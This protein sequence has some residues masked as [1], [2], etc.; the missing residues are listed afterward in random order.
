MLGAGARD[1]LD[2]PGLT[3][4]LQMLALVAF[5][6]ALDG[7]EQIGP[8]R[9]RA[10][11]AAPQPAGDGVHQE[12]R[13]RRQNEQTGQIVELLRPDLDEEEIEAAAGEI[14]QHRLT[15]C[16]W[17]AIPA[18]EGQQIVDAERDAQHD[19]LDAAISARHALRINLA[20]CRIER[21]FVFRLAGIAAGYKRCSRR[22]FGKRSERMR[23]RLARGGFQH[24]HRDIAAR[25]HCYCSPPPKVCI[26]TASALIVASSSLP[27]Q[28]G[29]T[30]PRPLM[31]PSMM[32]F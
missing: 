9:L 5:G 28:A 1:A 6:P 31:M 17:S 14:D 11:V 13:H 22:L 29:I 3:I 20:A 19:P 27:P 26:Y 10:Q 15:R 2:R 30:P 21:W 16:I 24:G 7:L 23:G 32:V 18:H 4:A 25:A 8:N 12:Q